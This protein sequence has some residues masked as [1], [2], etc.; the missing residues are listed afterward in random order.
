MLNPYTVYRKTE[1]G[2]T[3]VQVRA[4]G[5]RAVIS[6]VHQTLDEQFGVD[7]GQRFLDAVRGAA[8]RGPD[9]IE[10]V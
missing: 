1:A 5:L 3:E 10:P 9:P 2:V 6:E 7:T 4:L 8:A